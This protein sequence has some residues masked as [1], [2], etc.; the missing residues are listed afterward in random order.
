MR[1]A[2]QAEAAE[3]KINIHHAAPYP[4]RAPSREPKMQMKSSI[5]QNAGQG[6][7]SKPDKHAKIQSFAND[8]LHI[9]GGSISVAACECILNTLTGVAA[10]GGDAVL[11]EDSLAAFKERLARA[12]TDMQRAKIVAEALIETAADRAAFAVG[13]I[14]GVIPSGRVG[15]AAHPSFDGPRQRRNF[16]LPREQDALVNW[17]TE[18]ID[19]ANLYFGAQER[20]GDLGATE[21]GGAK[22]VAMH[23]YALLDHDRKAGEGD[24]EWAARHK[25]I[26]HKLA[27][28]TPAFIV[29][30]GGG[31]QA[32]FRV[33]ETTD[34]AEMTRR[35]V[36]LNN[37]AKLIGSD[38]TNSPEHIMRLPF[39]LNVLGKIKRERGREIALAWPILETDKP[40]IWNPD[41]LAAA[42]CEAFGVAAPAKA[43]PSRTVAGQQV[44]TANPSQQAGVLSIIKRALAALPNDPVGGAYN[45]RDDWLRVP[46]AVL[47]AGGEAARDLAEA[48]SDRY[49]VDPEGFD[50]AWRSLTGTSM[51]NLLVEVERH[52]PA[53]AQALRAEAAA[54]AFG[55][56]LDDDE[57]KAA[58]RRAAASA[59]VGGKRRQRASER[60]LGSLLST[61]AR[62]WCDHDRQPHVTLLTAGGDVRHWPLNDAAG[63]YAVQAVLD[64]ADEFLSGNDFKDLQERCAA[65]ARASGEVA[66]A[67]VRFAVD[68]Q[69]IVW[70]G[71]GNEVYSIM[72]RE[73]RALSMADSPVRFVRPDGTQANPTPVAPAPGETFLTLIERHLSLPP[74]V[75]ALDPED[76]GIAA[77]AALLAF[78]GGAVSPAEG[79]TRPAMIL[80]GPP[81]AGKST[82]A[83]RIGDL[84]DP[85][86]RAFTVAPRDTQH[87][88]VLAK[89]AG[90]VRLDNLSGINADTSDLLC[91]MATGATYTGRKLYSD[92]ELSAWRLSRPAILNGVDP[93]LRSDLVDRAVTLTLEPHARPWNEAEANARWRADKPQII[94]ALLDMLAS[95]L[96]ILPNVDLD[97]ANVPPPR[98]RQAATLAEACARALGWRDFLL[99]EALAVVAAEGQA[100]IVGGSPLAARLATVLAGRGGD[101]TATAADWLAAVGALHAPTWGP[102]G[103]PST[104]AAFSGALARI[105]TSLAA[106]G[107]TIKRGFTGRGADKRKT[108]TITAPTETL[109]KAT[110][111][112]LPF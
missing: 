110:R 50:K 18:N 33:E 71:G 15:V 74:V 21:A 61:G 76:A 38:P 28:L 80:L 65:K 12:A 62:F 42:L 112:D 67:P 83:L 95:A 108:I 46:A 93:A 27:K 8:I 56:D 53:L 19:R 91:C 11:D 81:R 59:A 90:I 5:P 49:R 101:W 22:D 86:S 106:T 66:D 35:K 26:T 99:V 96:A 37:A 72:P 10:D 82:T 51:E 109:P 20:R 73:W 31:V 57:V 40:K 25:E 7:Q 30:S 98:Y 45:D 87:L 9:N 69:T 100:G 48:W 55:D 32:W 52:N 4:A 47:G 84:L 70:D 88:A 3:P 41:E 39:T 103:G 36:I 105:E 78:T 89:N 1:T 97:K 92:G 17:I 107:W 24:A 111:D 60:A 29:Y 85:N 2:R 43:M 102:R 34:G 77:R 94:G 44:T 104:A 68:G 64:R 6:V 16:T 79:A 14:E 54:L 13:F 75:N 63:R 58:A 23:R